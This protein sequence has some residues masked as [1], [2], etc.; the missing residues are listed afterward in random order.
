MSQSVS[1]LLSV[2]FFL[3]IRQPPPPRT[4]IIILSP[5]PGL[6]KCS[7]FKLL[8]QFFIFIVRPMHAIRPFRLIHYDLIISEYLGNSTNCV[9]YSYAVFFNL[10]LFTPSK[11]QT[12]W[13]L[14]TLSSDTPNLSSFM[15]RHQVY[16][17]SKQQVKLNNNIFRDLLFFMP[18]VV[19]A[20]VA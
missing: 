18:R 6:S 19:T 9:T 20:E 15:M 5:T 17:H 14:S 4:E 11:A 2:A 3:E 10:L 7:Y 16:I 8:N 1:L 12:F 13:S